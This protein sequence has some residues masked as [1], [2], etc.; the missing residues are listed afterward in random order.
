MKKL[1]PLL[2]FIAACGKDEVSFPLFREISLP[3]TTDLS[4]VRFHDAMHGTISGGKAWESGFLLS[5]SDGGENWVFDTTLNRKMEHITFDPDGQGYACGQDLMLFRPVGAAHWQIQRVDFQWHRAAHFPSGRFGA[6]VSG[7]GYHDGQLGVFG[8]NAFWQL[9]TLHEVTGELEAVWYADS[10]TI[11]AVGTG[12]VIRSS[13][14]GQS[15]KGSIYNPRNGKSYKSF[16]TKLADG[17]L[18]VQGCVSFACK[19]FIYTPLK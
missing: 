11:L 2:L 15:W 7:E 10:M 3:T 12:W 4:A 9:D 6:V 1:L 19:S 8:P 13:D 14:A 16:L 5:T 18:K 17:T